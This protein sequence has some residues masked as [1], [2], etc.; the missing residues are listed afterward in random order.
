MYRFAVI[1]L[2]GV[3]ACMSLTAFAQ[4][5]TKSQTSPM[6]G[7]LI[8]TDAGHRLHLWCN[9][10]GPAPTVILVGGGGGYSIDWALVQPGIAANA[11]VCSYDRAGFAWSDKGP[12]PRGVGVSADELHQ[13]LRR[14]DVP[15]PYVLVGI[16]LGGMIARVFAHKYPDEVAGVV[17]IDS[18]LERTA[19]TATVPEDVF[20]SLDTRAEVESSPAVSFPP[21]MQAARAWATNLARQEQPPPT[22]RDGKVELSTNGM[23]W[24]APMWL[25]TSDLSE[26]E[27]AIRATMAGTKVPLGDK[28]LFVISAGRL[29]WDA[30]ARATGTSYVDALRAH[31]ANQAYAAGLS[32]NSQFVVARESFHNVIVYEPQLVTSAVLEI[33]ASV[34]TG[35]RLKS[36][37]E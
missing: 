8:A 3:V 25:E 34:R 26:P 33:L 36:L 14:A 18:T 5:E 30:Q 2:T 12:A 23:T 35:D 11:R 20:R 16:S 6:P 17:L 24:T 15:H 27:L 4:V 21:E 10:E 1:V 7:R 32:R 31:I 9:G 37:S 19:G 22:I 13:V 28:P 29:S